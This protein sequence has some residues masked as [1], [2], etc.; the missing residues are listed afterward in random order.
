MKNLLILIQI[1]LLLF[2]LSACQTPRYKHFSKVRR[3]MYKDQV[4][5]L[6]GAPKFSWRWK[7]RDRWKY[8]FPQRK[9]YLT[10][11]IHFI[12]GRVIYKGSPIKPEVSAEKQDAINLSQNEELQKRQSYSENNSSSETSTSVNDLDSDRNS[13]SRSTK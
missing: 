1:L 10:K 4:V 13:N 9:V 2:G 5:N 7:G 3:G 11:E 6:I 8:V 12:N